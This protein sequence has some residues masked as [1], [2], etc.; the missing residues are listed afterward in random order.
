MPQ[1]FQIFHM[2]GFKRLFFA[3]ILLAFA[4]TASAADAR[5]L[6]S[7]LDGVLARHVDEGYVDY[8]ALARNTR[9]YKYLGA[10][11]EFD[12]STLESDAARLTFWINAYNA[13]AMKSIIEG[14]RPINAIGRIKF[15]RT[16]EHRV[17]G[18]NRDLRSIGE[19][20]VLEM[21]E[22]RAHFALVSACYSC[23]NLR[24]EAYRVEKLEQQLEDNTREFVNDGRKNRFSSA[25]RKAKLSELFDRHR[26][27]FGEDDQAL[28]EFVA[29]YIEKGK[30]AKEILRDRYKID[31]LEWDWSI[32]GRP[33]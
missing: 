11:E 6:H 28:L 26:D 31:Y 20:I 32:N 12:L 8:P 21:E 10:I 5:V 7:L 16:T 23:P 17:A 2:S 3:L 18:K 13:L 9:F 25:A 15:F 27:D 14:V 1:L 4:R 29:P 19:G 30:F 33:M 24:S 22:P